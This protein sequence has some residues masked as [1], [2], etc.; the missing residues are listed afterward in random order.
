MRVPDGAWRAHAATALPCG[1]RPQS[2]SHSGPFLPEWELTKCGHSIM[3]LWPC[4]T[5][6]SF[7]CLPKGVLTKVLPGELSPTLAVAL[8]R[9][10]DV[11][12]LQ[13]GEHCQLQGL[14]LPMPSR[15]TLHSS[16]AGPPLCSRE[17]QWPGAAP[18]T[19]EGIQPLKGR[20]SLSK[21]LTDVRA[22]VGT[23]SQRHLL[24]E[25]ASNLDV[26]SARDPRKHLPCGPLAPLPQLRAFQMDT[27]FSSSVAI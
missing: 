27:L 26:I 11:A 5:G 14:G 16:W 8:E 4:E 17:D 24:F 20:G 3:D 9:Q 2:H 6:D 13:W 1:C 22:L 19:A 12:P 25:F 18:R 23:F 10:D 7:P 15:P 21:A